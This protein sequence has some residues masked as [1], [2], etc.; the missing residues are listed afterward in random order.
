MS[1]T[2]IGK[3]KI[4]ISVEGCVDCGAL[5]AAGWATERIIAVQ[6]GKRRATISIPICLD[7]LNKRNRSNAPFNGGGEVFTQSSRNR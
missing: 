5:Y 1:L 7:C 4:D 2:T 3:T 6:I